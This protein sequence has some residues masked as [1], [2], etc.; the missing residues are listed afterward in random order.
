MNLQNSW[1]QSQYSE[2]K[3][4]LVHHQLDIRNRNQETNP[5]RYSKKRNKVHK[6]KPNHGSKR[7]VH[8][9]IQNNNERI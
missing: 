5:I 1:I 6:N 7:L 2:I 4:I 3:G 8:L 9:K